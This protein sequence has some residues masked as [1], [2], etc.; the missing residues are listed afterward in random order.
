M[1]LKLFL[2]TRGHGLTRIKTALLSTSEPR[3]ASLKIRVHLP[4]HPWFQMNCSGGGEGQDEDGPFYKPVQV[5]WMGG[6]WYIWQEN[7]E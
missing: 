2:T 1:P 7:R 6:W 3:R 5:G 4:V